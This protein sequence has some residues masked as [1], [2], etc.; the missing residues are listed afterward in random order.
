MFVVASSNLPANIVFFFFTDSEKM[1]NFA[2]LFHYFVNKR[3]HNWS[4]AKLVSSWSCD[5]VPT[6]AYFFTE[7]FRKEEAC[8][9]GQE[10]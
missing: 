4:S 1:N 6:P 7:I 5:Q 3:K 8:T 9:V 2:I 10:A